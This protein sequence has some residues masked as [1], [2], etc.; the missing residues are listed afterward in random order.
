MDFLSVG[1]NHLL[2]FVSA[3]GKG[4]LEAAQGVSLVILKRLFLTRLCF[5]HFFWMR[6]L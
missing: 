2:S 6:G 4:F 5:I 1:A 3:D